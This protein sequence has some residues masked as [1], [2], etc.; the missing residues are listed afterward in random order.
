MDLWQGPNLVS[1]LDPLDALRRELVAGA[2][3][4]EADGAVTPDCLDEDTIAALAEGSLSPEARATALP[5]LAQC[6]RCRRAVASI[7]RAL[8][9]PMVAS[10]VSALEPSSRRRWLRIAVPVAA[11]ALLLLFLSPWRNDGWMHRGPVGTG[12]GTPVPVTPMGAVLT[13]PALQW[14]RVAEADRYRA[15]L[16]DAEG[17]VLYEVEVTDTLVALPDSIVLR[18]GSPYLWKVEARI[19]WNR[20]A[21]SDLTRFSVAG[22]SAP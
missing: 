17:H 15:T 1:P 13:A 5:H 6:A 7:A 8:A 14:T 2:G 22:G 21:A 9:D 19:G 10:E 20:W 16:F 11:A 4:P 12:Q 18:S 3:L